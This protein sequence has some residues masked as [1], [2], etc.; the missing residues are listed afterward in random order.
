MVLVCW[1]VIVGVS[2]HLLPFQDQE[3]EDIEYIIIIEK[4]LLIPMYYK[5]T[6]SRWNVYLV[7]LI[8]RLAP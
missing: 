1:A 4:P 7:S 3:K 8:S 6:F 2:G 5:M